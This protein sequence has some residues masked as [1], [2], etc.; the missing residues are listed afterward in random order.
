MVVHNGN[1]HAAEGASL[2]R[3]TGLYVRRRKPMRR[4]AST[5]LILIAFASAFAERLTIRD[6]GEY[7][8]LAADGKPTTLMYRFSIRD[9]KWLAEGKEGNEP[10]RNISCD[11]GCEYRVST[12]VEAVNY[13]PKDARQRFR[14]SCVQNVAQ[15]FCRYTSNLNS[16]HVGYVV[17][18]LV[19]NPPRAIPL[20]RIN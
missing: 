8:V 6:G 20:R 4:V 3:P 16:S 10:W 13:L 19:V 14:I 17:M 2:F 7:V 11:K 1:L 12:E 5:A 18:A 9:R 15:A